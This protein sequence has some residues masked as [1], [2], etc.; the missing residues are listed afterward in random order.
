MHADMNDEK[1]ILTVTVSVPTQLIQCHKQKIV[2]GNSIH[3]TNFKIMPKTNYDRGNCDRIIS[4]N[5]TSTIETIPPIC[6]EYTF[7]PNTT[8]K[9]LS[10]T[11]SVGTIGVLVTTSRK[12]GIQHNLQIMD[13]NSNDDKSKLTFYCAIYCLFNYLIFKTHAY[14]N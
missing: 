1:G 5:E 11:H 6:N 8:V 2:A 13:E 10:K 3:I 9:Q 7:I 14:I 4:L 12:I